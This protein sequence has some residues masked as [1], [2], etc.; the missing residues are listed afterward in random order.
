M[1]SMLGM[2]TIVILSNSQ[3]GQWNSLFLNT[4]AQTKTNVFLS[5]IP[6]PNH[7]LQNFEPSVE[8]SR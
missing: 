1:Q 6:G 7:L 2:E 4:L 3:M 5:G 8:P